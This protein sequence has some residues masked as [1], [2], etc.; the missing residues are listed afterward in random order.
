MTFVDP[1]LEIRQVAVCYG[2]T[3]QHPLM[4]L[5]QISLSVHRG[6]FVGLVGPS[7]CGKSTLLSLVA[8]LHSPTAGTVTF[9]DDTRAKRTGRIA[10]MPQR[11]A[12]LPW[13]RALD[14]AITG[15][16]VQGVPR[17]QARERAKKLFAA[18]GLTGCE[19]A[20]PAQLSGGMRQRVA[21]ART[22]L[23]G[24]NLLLL[25]EPFGALDALTRMHLQEWLASVWG[26]L[27]TAC[28]FVTHDIDEALRLADRIYVLTPQ[29]GRVCLERRVPLERDQRQD[30]FTHP[31]M[32]SLKM[33]LRNALFYDDRMGHSSSSAPYTGDMLE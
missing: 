7:G 12:L 13:R 33:E 22:V 1:L 3:S 5:E 17:T 26:T 29:P 23:V 14:N 15:L 25:D 10:Y 6:E 11:D 16:E 31:E 19:R 18:F 20:Y 9:H 8:G 32:I 24:S 28:L 21:F 2:A 4:A 30:M 27:G